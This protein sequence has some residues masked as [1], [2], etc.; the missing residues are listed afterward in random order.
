MALLN[1]HS[2][3]HHSLSQ[4]QEWIQFSAGREGSCEAYLP[5]RIL[6]GIQDPVFK[7][8]STGGSDVDNDVTT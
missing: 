7:V 3:S 2:L 5:C 8:P 6:V 4:P 1:Y